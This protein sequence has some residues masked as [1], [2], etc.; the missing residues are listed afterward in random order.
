MYRL[1][2]VITT[3]GTADEGMVID[4]GDLK[5]IAMD[6]ID[7]GFDHGYMIYEKDCYI[8]FFRGIC[9]K[10]GMKIIEVDFVPTAENIYL[11]LREGGY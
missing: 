11:W 6:I 3:D 9:I 8:D 7:G 5:Q 1:L 4:F 10:D 2:Q